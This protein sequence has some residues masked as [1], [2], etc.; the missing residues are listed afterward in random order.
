MPTDE[1][2][3]AIAALG[4]F[5]N[6]D[7]VLYGSVSDPKTSITPFIGSV[8]L[9]I[10][11]QFYLVDSQSSA[12]LWSEKHRLVISG[13]ASTPS[14]REMIEVIAAGITDRL[15]ELRTGQKQEEATPGMFECGGRFRPDIGCAEKE[16]SS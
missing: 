9:T 1:R 4:K 8:T 10:P 15:M 6:V 13:G 16:E 11:I 7:I 14:Q 2:Y 5:T 3:K 12:V